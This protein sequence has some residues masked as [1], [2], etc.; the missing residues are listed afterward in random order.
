VPG[1]GTAINVAAIIVGGLLGLTISGDLS[2]TR[3]K[4]LRK[5]IGFLI[6]IAGF[7]MV[8]EG[9]REV[10]LGAKFGLVGIALLS[11]SL[12]RP[13]G[14][15]LHIQA[16]M[17][18]LGR[19][20]GGLFAKVQKDESPRT[21]NDGFVACAIL[22]CVTPLAVLGPIQDGMTGNF[23]TLAVTF[24][25]VF[26]VSV[27]FTALP[28]LAI[29]G[30]LTLLSIWLTQQFASPAI[31]SALNVTG[32]LLVVCTTLIVFEAK[33]VALG[34]FLPALGVAGLLAWWWM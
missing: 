33:K 26:G 28:V 4:Q 12:G 10:G 20:A 29:Q 6:V 1:T 16:G 32:G 9:V 31:L 11:T 22:F 8:W 13:V 2:V 18:R 27:V 21:F 24:A 3:Q 5:W 15:L 34:D 30:T 17:D 25:R 19:H 23:V 14:K 7:V